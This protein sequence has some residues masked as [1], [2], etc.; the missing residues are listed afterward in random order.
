[1][2]LVREE[3]TALTRMLFPSPERQ[4]LMRLE[5]AESERDNWKYTCY[6]II[7]MLVLLIIIGRRS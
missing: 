5:T 4:A 7:G 1:L 2:A 6:G 3:V